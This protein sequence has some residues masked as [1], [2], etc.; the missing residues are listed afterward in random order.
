MR[1]ASVCG[2]GLPA[3]GRVWAAGRLLLGAE[4]REEDQ[5]AGFARWAGW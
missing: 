4:V 1:V 3:A 5:S 2:I